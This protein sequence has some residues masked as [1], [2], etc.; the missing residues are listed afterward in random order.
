MP[1]PPRF[2]LAIGFGLVLSLA[3]AC[4]GAARELPSDPPLLPNAT[5][6]AARLQFRI[7]PHSLKM[8]VPA[9]PAPQIQIVDTAGNV[10]NTATNTITLSSGSGNVHILGNTT[11][12]A[13]GGFATFSNVFP[14]VCCTTVQLTATAVGLASASTTGITIS[15]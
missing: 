2:V 9:S 13:V 6:P 14:D 5:G 7:Q 10:V 4:G 11:V 12:Q 1:R 8:N 15:N 3:G